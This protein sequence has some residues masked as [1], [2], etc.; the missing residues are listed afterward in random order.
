MADTISLA[1]ETQFALRAEVAFQEM[2][3]LNGTT[4]ESFNVVGYQK[5]FTRVE[6]GVATPHVRNAILTNGNLGTTVTT[7]ELTGYDFSQLIDPFDQSKVSWDMMEPYCKSIGYSLAR[8]SLQSKINAF[9][10]GTT[11][12]VAV[13][14]GLTTGTI[15]LSVKKINRARALMLKKG[16][17]SIPGKWHAA[18]SAFALESALNDD[19]ISN[20]DYNILKALYEGSMEN[21][22]GF[23]FHV[24]ADMAE[25]GLP[26]D[27]S[28]YRKCYFWYNDAVGYAESINQGMDGKC[29][30]DW[31]T[32]H[33]SWRALGRIGCGAKVIDPNGIVEVLVDESQAAA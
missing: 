5:Q 18:I 31:D 11:Q 10:A 8:A 15:G 21:Y 27:S 13:D 7:L 19:K 30:V 22:S 3:S 20:I 2:Q 25:G 12:T 29:R 33:G 17:P 23:T 1:F 28:G 26:I 4:Q 32:L 6:P 24:I 9:E 14:Y 16:V